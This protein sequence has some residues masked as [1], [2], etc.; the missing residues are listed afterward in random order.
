M[1]ST[2]WFQ[3]ASVKA[4]LMGP[5]L[6]AMV[7]IL[8]TDKVPLGYLRLGFRKDRLKTNQRQNLFMTLGGLLLAF[9]LLGGILDRTCRRVTSPIQDLL[10]EIRRM[11]AGDL[12][13]HLVITSRDEIGHLASSFGGLKARLRGVLGAFAQ[14]ARANFQEAEQLSRQART[15]A[16]RT[17]EISTSAHVS[18]AG[19][20]ALAGA[21]GRL[22]DSI[23]EIEKRIQ[24]SRGQTQAVA[25][26]TDQGTQ[27]GTA[28][29]EAMDQVNQTLDG[30][31]K[32]L[33]VISNLARQTNLLSLNAAIEAAKA[34][35]HGRGFAVVA[36]E[37][38]KLAEHSSLAA[39]DIGQLIE[40]CNAVVT[41]ADASVTIT[42]QALASIHA[43]IASLMTMIEGI[44]TA[45][46]DEVATSDTLSAQIRDNASEITHNDHSAQELG[47]SV[48]SIRATAEG[49]ARIGQQLDNH[50][51]AFQ[52]EET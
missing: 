43:S 39:K 17:E 42:V 21:V 9:V 2:G 29:A 10:D 44:H 27:A 31:G 46:R 33:A 34:G 11:E 37:V 50:L 25:Q 16:E 30:I 41:R 13:G 47:Q 35:E 48:Q 51:A 4:R 49:L 52:L 20:E 36:D 24:Q 18:K 45:S 14:L 3:A 5:V 26:A 6:V 15:M 32:A 23:R 19:S 7:L 40:L 8:A 22:H 38:R 28:V 12:R 1:T